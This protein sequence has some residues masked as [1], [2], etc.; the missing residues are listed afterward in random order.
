MSFKDTHVAGI[1]VLGLILFAG[2]H[3][4]PQGHETVYF[5]GGRLLN[6]TGTPGFNWALPWPVTSCEHVEV[7]YQTDTLV[8]VACGSSMG[9]TARFPKIE[10]VNRLHSA[11]VLRTVSEHTVH[12]DRR[13][14]YD[15]IPTEVAQFCKEY[16]LEQI[17]V[18]EFDK[19]DEKLLKELRANVE[20]YNLTERVE[21]KAVRIFRP[22]LSARMQK[23][24]E[25]QEQEEKERDLQEKRRITQQV[26]LQMEME[27]QVHQSNMERNMSRI[28]Q[29]RRKEEALAEAAR[30]AIEANATFL[31]QKKK[32]D[33]DLYA[34]RAQARGNRELYNNSQYVQV[35]HAQALH[36]NAKELIHMQNDP[37][38]TLFQQSAP[39]PTTPSAPILNL[40]HTASQCSAAR[41]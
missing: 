7:R 33:G 2:L 36:N 34:A 21:I 26:T 5:Q 19:L 37:V 20:S 39:S 13:L 14:I 22:E 28:D 11:C 17:F 40:N 23:A 25:E 15:Y 8:N 29:G 30:S 31:T 18:K 12:Y 1:V 24:F 38:I 3:E 27:K 32:A 41:E 16:K 6:G 35:L 10:V 4:T 9:G